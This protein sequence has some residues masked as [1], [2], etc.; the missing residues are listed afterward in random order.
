MINRIAFR[1]FIHGEQKHLLC[2]DRIPN[3]MIN[4]LIGI[5]A[6]T[7][8]IKKCILE[9]VARFENKMHKKVSFGSLYHTGPYMFNSCMSN[10]QTCCKFDVP[11]NNMDYKNAP[12]DDTCNSK[13]G[14]GICVC[15]L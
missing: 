1:N 13:T 2:N 14:I 5:T 11:F 12:L 9:C 15:D 3:A 6:K 7:P 10:Y 4:G 8:Q